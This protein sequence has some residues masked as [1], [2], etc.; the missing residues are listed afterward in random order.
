MRRFVV[1][2]GGRHGG[3]R[4]LL[5]RD[6]FSWV[7][8]LVPAIWLLA[9]R[10]ILSGLLVL[11]AQVAVLAAAARLGAEGAGLAVLVLLS[12]AVALEG[13]RLRVWRARRHGAREVAI[14]HAA[15][16]EEAELIYFGSDP[17]IE[18][19]GDPPSKPPAAPPRRPLPVLAGWRSGH[20]LLATA[21]G[22]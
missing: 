5:V 12:L 11:A 2:G 13:P 1:L 9:H 4:A 22:R 8:F 17:I 14:V 16:H 20:T 6:H 3:E 15:S 21:R 7:A 18:D 19:A 10:L